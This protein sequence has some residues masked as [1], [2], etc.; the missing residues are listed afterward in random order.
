MIFQIFVMFIV[1]NNTYYIFCNF[2]A[3]T[4]QYY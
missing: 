4:F 2:F 1:L 3:L